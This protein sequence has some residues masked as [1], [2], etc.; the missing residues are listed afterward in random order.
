MTASDSV[1]GEV[2]SLLPRLAACSIVVGIVVLALKYCAYLATGSIALLSDAIE[3][4]INVVT[5]IAAFFAIRLSLQP[6]D[7][8][9]PFGHT[10]AEY[11]S[12]VLEGVLIIIAAIAILREA[13]RGFLAPVPIE[14]PALGLAVNAVASLINAAWCW[15]LIRAG[16]RHRSPALVADGM[17]LLT[18]VVSSAGVIL[19]VVLVALTGWT[20]LDP[21]LAAAVAINILWSG[22]KLLKE[23]GGGLMD[24]ALPEAE[25]S[26]VRRIIDGAMTGAIEAHALRTRQAGRMIFIDF[27]LVVGGTLTVDAAHRICDHI[28]EALEAR[29]PDSLVSIHVEPE[30]KREHPPRP[31]PALPSGIA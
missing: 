5:A 31:I 18:D 25:L 20:R 4:I 19:G 16:R 27:H 1:P 29:F 3:S 13:Y 30:W 10:K 24:A 9:H 21:L 22:W 23:S 6:P 8:G 28:E 11:L 2:A 15:V 12:A 7:A 26:E 17:H 14:A